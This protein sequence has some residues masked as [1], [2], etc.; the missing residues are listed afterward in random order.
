MLVSTVE[1]KP[2]S[3]QAMH[4]F[5][6]EKNHIIK[7][8]VEQSMERSEEIIH[9]GNNAKQILSSG[10]TFTMEMLEAAML[11]GELDLLKDQMNWAQKRLPHDGVYP[12]HI[13]NRLK[14]LDAVISQIIPYEYT[15]EIH[16]Y[17]QWMIDEQKKVLDYEKIT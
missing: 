15:T 17:L 11:V 2:I 12:S 13:F 7:K 16:P 1:I 6:N 9:H 3:P 10:Y 4:S 8:A 5:Q 14:I